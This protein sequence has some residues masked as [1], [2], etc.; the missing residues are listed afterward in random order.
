MNTIACI[1]AALLGVRYPA[2]KRFLFAC[3]ARSV[4]YDAQFSRLNRDL[5]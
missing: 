5:E 4:L 1:E 3:R 2:R